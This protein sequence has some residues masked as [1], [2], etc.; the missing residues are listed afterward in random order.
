MQVINDT[1]AGGRFG[2]NLGSGLAQLAQAKLE[3]ISEKYQNTQLQ[4]TLKSSGLPNNIVNLLRGIDEKTRG[5]LL[6]NL[7]LNALGE[8]D[9]YQ[10]PEQQN[11]LAMLIQQLQQNQPQLNQASSQRQQ[12]DPYQ[13]LL[14]AASQFSGPMGQLQQQN[15]GLGELLQQPQQQYAQQPFN[16]QAFEQNQGQEQPQLQGQERAPER[17]PLFKSPH[18][19]E[20]REEEKLELQK[21]KLSSLENREI[22]EFSKPYQERAEK[23]EASIRDYQQLMKDAR[24]GQLRAGNMYQLLDA[25]GLGDFGRNATTE[26]A[27]KAIARLSQNVSGVF[28]SNSRIT[29][30]LEQVF[31]RSIPSLKNTPKGI[32][33]IS[34]LNMAI[35]EAAIVKDQIRQQVIQKYGLGAD[36]PD[37]IK[38]YS[39]PLI[40]QIDQEAFAYVD[41]LMNSKGKEGYLEELPPAKYY[42]GTEIEGEDGLRRVSNGKDWVVKSP[43]KKKR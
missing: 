2:A 10:Q 26:T 3:H 13:Q 18:A 32:E 25:L 41:N 35:E 23:A 27:G 36:T 40:K 37:L 19:H 15:G 22:R 21:R 20:K 1:N 4:K 17:K 24:S 38:K 43:G 42:L 12:E 28:G 39:A 29:N 33:M 30:F 14:Q 31:Q 16:E 8:Q 11:P 7:D 34:A 9:Q 5:S 6:K